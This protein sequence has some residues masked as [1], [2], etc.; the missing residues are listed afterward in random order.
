ME[1]KCNFLLGSNI[2]DPWYFCEPGSVYW[3]GRTLALGEHLRSIIWVT[4]YA[5][6]LLAPELQLWCR[7]R[8]PEL[9]ALDICA[10]V[11]FLIVLFSNYSH[12]K[13]S[14]AQLN[15]FYGSFGYW[16]ADVSRTNGSIM[17]EIFKYNF[18]TQCR[19]I[20]GRRWK[21]ASTKYSHPTLQLVS[22]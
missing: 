2:V 13:M 19:L 5:I 14:I 10:S 1:H 12:R 6:L 17:L 4:L 22:P 16:A 11:P 20:N 21:S 18:Q 8:Y 9:G 7:I 15:I 3:G